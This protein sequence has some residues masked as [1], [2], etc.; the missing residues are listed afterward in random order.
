VGQQID[1]VMDNGSTCSYRISAVWR[2]V[3]AVTGYP[4]LVSREHLYDQQGPERLF[5]ETCGGP[6]LP[7]ARMFKDINVVIATPVTG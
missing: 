7:S 5:L 4:Q 2:N 6:W 1:L 3:D